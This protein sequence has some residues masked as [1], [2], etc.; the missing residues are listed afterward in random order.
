[1]LEHGGEV[2]GVI[3][4]AL[5]QKEVAHRGLADLRIVQSMHERKAVMAALSDGFVALPGGIGTLEELFEVWT[6]AQL[7][8]HAKPCAIYNVAR[9]YDGLTAFLDQV[10]TCGF[11]R[12]AHREMLIVESTASGLLDR[13]RSYRPPDATKWIDPGER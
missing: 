11:L 3:P 12:P 2:I 1:V 6:W 8:D 7:G 4:D 10:V 5:V 9:F 13:L